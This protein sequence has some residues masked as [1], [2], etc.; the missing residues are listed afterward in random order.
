MTNCNTISQVD[1]N[2]TCSRKYVPLSKSVLT[3][4]ELL[5][6]MGVTRKEARQQC[7]YCI[8]VQTPINAVVPNNQ[9]HVGPSVTKSSDERD[10]GR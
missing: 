6:T 1:Y 5:G 4:P 3:E 9:N 2:M 10:C 8:D 7:F